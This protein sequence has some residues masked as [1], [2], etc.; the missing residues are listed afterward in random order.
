MGLQ[1]DTEVTYRALLLKLA[2]RR[3][4]VALDGRNTPRPRGPKKHQKRGLRGPPLGAQITTTQIDAGTPQNRSGA[5]SSNSDR[6][7]DFSG[8]PEKRPGVKINKK[9]RF[10]GPKMGPKNSYAGTL[11]D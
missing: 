3:R 2:R 11:G 8:N 6:G 7:T 4:Q 10:G 1:G 9:V 5:D